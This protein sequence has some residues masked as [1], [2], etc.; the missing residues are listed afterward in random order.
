[1]GKCSDYTASKDGFGKHVKINYRGS[2]FYGTTFGGS[3][4]LIA[5]VI[6][7]ALAAGSVW[8]CFF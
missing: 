7:L 5:Q 6:I 1:M 2:N 3:V 4:S 8:A